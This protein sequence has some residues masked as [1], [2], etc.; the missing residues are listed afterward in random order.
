M[1]GNLTYITGDATR[2]TFEGP[3]IIAHGCNTVG[4]WGAGFVMAISARWSKPCDEYLKNQDLGMNKLGSVHFVQVE[5]DIW[6]ANMITQSGIYSTANPRP[7]N[8][9]AVEDC[10]EFLALHAKNLKATIHMP[11]IGT[12]LAKGRWDEIEDRIQQKL[13]RTGIDVFVYDLPPSGISV[14][15]VEPPK[16]QRKKKTAL[17]D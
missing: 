13:C 12:G 8:Y 9:E 16:K 5:D 6:V 7:L 1:T 10:L 17:Q 14:P 2:P 3:K 15:A 11:R 4:A